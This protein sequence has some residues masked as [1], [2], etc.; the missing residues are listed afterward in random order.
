MSDISD[1]N[2]PVELE[3]YLADG[4]ADLKEYQRNQEANKAKHQEELA[5]AAAEAMKQW[6][7]RVKDRVPGVALQFTVTSGFD[8]YR[9][10]Y[11]AELQIPECAP[12][13]VRQDS[14]Q[15]FV[16]L[17]CVPGK[18]TFGDPYYCVPTCL[19]D[20]EGQVYWAARGVERYDEFEQALAAAHQVYPEKAAFEARMAERAAR[21]EAMQREKARAEAEQ[22]DN[23]CHIRVLLQTDHT[24]ES[25]DGVLIDELTN[26]ADRLTAIG[27]LMLMRHQQ[28]E[29]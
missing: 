5:Q 3:T 11:E 20:N 6:R 24:A 9:G 18:E 23:E 4:Q 15:D 12:I 7:E 10:T 1:T 27:L 13:Y 17:D 19:D 26:I 21:Y 22:R 16:G 14:Q 29:G 25:C 28:E 2:F 8:Q